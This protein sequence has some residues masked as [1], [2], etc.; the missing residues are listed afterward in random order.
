[1]VNTKSPLKISGIGHHLCILDTKKYGFLT[2]LKFY[3]LVFGFPLRVIFVLR[4]FLLINCD[5][6]V[7]A[8]QFLEIVK[9]HFNLDVRHMKRLYIIWNECLSKKQILAKRGPDS[10]L[11]VEANTKAL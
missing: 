4:V 10:R 7:F 2:R 6:I 11:V 1:M 9:L 3:C 5:E 8:S